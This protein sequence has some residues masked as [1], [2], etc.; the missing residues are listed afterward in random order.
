MNITFILK[1]YLS[2]NIVMKVMKLLK[3]INLILFILLIYFER[4]EK[5]TI[6]IWKMLSTAKKK[7]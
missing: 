5:I 6:I 3:V 1:I 7:Y 4:K 2:K